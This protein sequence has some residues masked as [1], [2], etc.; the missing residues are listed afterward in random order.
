MNDTTARIQRLEE[1]VN[2][3]LDICKRLGK[4]N[5]DLRAQMQALSGERATLLEQKEQVRS[6]VEAMITRLRSME[7]A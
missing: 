4:D 5:I 3:L 6:Q 7:S 2:Q 1:Q